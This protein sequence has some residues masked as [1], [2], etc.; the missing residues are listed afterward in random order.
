MQILSLL[1]DIVAPPSTR[2]FGDGSFSSLL[3]IVLAGIALSAFIFFGGLWIV[4]R[5]KKPIPV[6]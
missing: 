6:A 5:R 2:S 4:R 1:G 3:P